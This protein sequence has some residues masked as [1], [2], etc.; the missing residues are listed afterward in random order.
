MAVISTLL[1]QPI[2]FLR[3]LKAL[4]ITNSY[5]C[6]MLKY[7]ILKAVLNFYLIFS[8]KDYKEKN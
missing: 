4:L 7:A 8:I 5:N 2:H 3:P 1:F 6:K